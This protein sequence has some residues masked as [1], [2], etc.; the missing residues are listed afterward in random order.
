MTLYENL[1]ETAQNSPSLSVWNATKY[2]FNCYYITLD[3]LY[4]IQKVFKENGMDV[5][6]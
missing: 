2:A 5:K 4:T 1:L 3:E 6:Y